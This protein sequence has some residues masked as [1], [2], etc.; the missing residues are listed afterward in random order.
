MLQP[1]YAPPRVVTQ[2]FG[3]SRTELFRLIAQKK[4]VSIH[5]KTK[6][7]ARKGVRLIDLNSVRTFLKGFVEQARS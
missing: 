5:Y 4:I 6:P 2:V 1:E 7:T 3:L